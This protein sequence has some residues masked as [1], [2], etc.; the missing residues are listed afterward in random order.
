MLV[1]ATA[2]S[3]PF[4]AVTDSGLD[5]DPISTWPKSMAPGLRWTIG[6]VSPVPLSA[7]ESAPPRIL[8]DT[9]S[10]PVRVPASAGRKVTWMVQLAPAFT[11]VPLQ[12]SVSLNSPVTLIVPGRR[13]MPPVLVSVT[14]WALLDCPN[15][16]FPKS[17]DRGEMAAVVKGVAAVASGICHSP[18]PKV[19]ATRTLGKVDGGA[20][21]N[22][23]TGAF[24][25][26]VPNTDQ[27]DCV[28]HDS[29]S[30]VM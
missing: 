3:P 18:R 12:L 4:S 22:A 10:W 5:V 1:I 15:P 26:P 23:T 20:A 27:H 29:T 13:A 8:T 14:V 2:D 11:V 16:C 9:E 28:A 17:I 24:G 25:S 30:R 7:T 21:L 6:G 19:P